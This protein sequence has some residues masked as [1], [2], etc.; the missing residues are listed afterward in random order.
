MSFIKMMKSRE[1]LELMKDP[2]VFMLLTQIASRAKRTNN[3][4]IYGLEIGE[5]LIGDY[6]SIGLTRGQY[7]EAIKRAEK[8]NLITTIR[9][10]N[11]G[12]VVKLINSDIFDINQETAQPP[13]QIDSNHPTTTNKNKK[14]EK[15]NIYNKNQI[16]YQAIVDLFNKTLSELPSIKVV[17]D[18]RKKHLKARWYFSNKT[19]NLKWWNEFFEYIRESDFLMGRKTDW[20]AS[21][22]WIIKPTNFV[23]IIEGNYHK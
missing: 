13:T 3:F 5:A 4:S 7:R 6:E 9:T 20:R 19:S 10:T 8:Y 17:T 1:T 15:N 22:D 2:N 14:K 12:T 21:F 18:K 16:P 11:R 23:K